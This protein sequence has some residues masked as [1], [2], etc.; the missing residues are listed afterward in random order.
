M[1]G[2]LCQSLLRLAQLGFQL[3]QR[4]LA[5][6]HGLLPAVNQHLL[7]DLRW[8]GRRRFVL[9]G[10]GLVEVFHTAR[11]VAQTEHAVEVGGEVL[12]NGAATLV[13]QRV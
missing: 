5:G 7:E 6:G 12:S 11:A 10:D 4:R 9:L 2:H 13:S 8:N 1:S 3:L